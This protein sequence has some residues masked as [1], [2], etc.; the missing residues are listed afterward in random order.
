MANPDQ[1]SRVLL[2][3]DKKDLPRLN[4]F[5]NDLKEK[6]FLSTAILDRITLALEEVFINIVD[7]GYKDEKTHEIEIQATKTG[8]R[9]IILCKDDGVPF[10]PLEAPPPDITQ[11][12]QE[13]EVGGL[14][15]LLIQRMIDKID[16]RRENETNILVLQIAIQEDAN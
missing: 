10:N 2:S 16:Y 7:H 8:E 11:P 9:L 5:I 12:L 4:I 15:I 6:W 14:G 1:I 3:N 13:R